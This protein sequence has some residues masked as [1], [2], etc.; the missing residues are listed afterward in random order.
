MLLKRTLL[1]SISA[2]LLIGYGCDD[3]E[4]TCDI[5]PALID[6]ISFPALGFLITR[7]GDNVFDDDAIA[8]EDVTVRG[9]DASNTELGLQSV[10]DSINGPIFFF[11]DTD[12]SSGDYEYLIELDTNDSFS[13]NSTFVISESLCCGNI[14][15]LEEIRIN[16]ME[17]SRDDTSG[18]F[19][20]ILD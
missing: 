15:I 10:F 3:D 16:D 14:P 7:N 11:T 12:W 6:C 19:V 17:A 8:L 2:C 1:L 5:D 4:D 9:R 20:V 18:L 13:I